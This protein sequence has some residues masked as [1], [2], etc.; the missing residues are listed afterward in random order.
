MAKK[1]LY[2]LFL[3]F[4]MTVKSFAQVSFGAGAYFINDFAGGGDLKVGGIE[5]GH[6]K[7]PFKGG[8]AYI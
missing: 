8:G 2:V 1:Y 3:F 5:V 7:T 6:L 4:F